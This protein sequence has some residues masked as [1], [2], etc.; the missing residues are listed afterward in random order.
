METVYN[1]PVSRGGFNKTGFRHSD[2]IIV[3]KEVAFAVL[4]FVCLQLLLS[5]LFIV[6]ELDVSR[7]CFIF[8]LFQNS[9][10]KKFL[11]QVPLDDSPQHESYDGAIRYDSKP[12]C[13]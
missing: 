8:W 3:D 11:K 12:N 13:Q 10:D 2:K 7:R 1:I 4:F 5:L 6:L 9:I